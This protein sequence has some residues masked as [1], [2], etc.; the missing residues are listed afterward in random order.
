MTTLVLGANGQVGRELLTALRPL[1]TVQAA[2]RDGI[3]AQGGMCEAAD[4]DQPRS[5]PALL[6]R[7]QPR[8]VVNAAAWTAVDR[9]EQDEAAAMRVNAESPGV[10]ARWCARH[11]VPLVHYSTDYVF[12]GQG[13]RPYREEDATAPLGAY[14]RSK[15]AG[16][17]AVQAA[18][19]QHLIL[20]TAWVHAAHGHN[21]L[22]TMLRLAATQ[23]VL[24]VVADQIGAPT[25]ATL[26][27][28]VTAW[29]LQQRPDASG[30][31]HLTAGGST[32]WHGFAQ[33]IFADAVATGL[34][35]DA[36]EVV[37]ITTADYPTPAR[38]PAYSCLDTS[39]LRNDFGI[40]LPD[41]RDDVRR[42][43]EVMAAT[44]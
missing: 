28:S 9:A 35:A 19:G 7:V 32:S 6:A 40:A 23:P 2:T 36:P 5:L 30:L 29:M 25:S 42:V 21:F 10:I 37:A 12:D 43:V 27:A 15:R 18:G 44:P 4:L 26:I 31:W 17:L 20:R 34:F 11:D 1:G 8:I 22:R 39:L 24:R 14:G 41:W 33:A 13:R 3:L 16:E 38:R